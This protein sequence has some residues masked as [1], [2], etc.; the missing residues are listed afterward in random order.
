MQSHGKN[1]KKPFRNSSPA[2]EFRKKSLSGAW[3]GDFGTKER[4]KGQGKDKG[5]R[6]QT[7]EKIGSR[8]GD[9]TRTINGRRR[10]RA[11]KRYMRG[12]LKRCMAFCGRVETSEHRLGG[13][14]LKGYCMTR[15]LCIVS[16]ENDGIDY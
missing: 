9:A 16:A 1:S 6:V 7:G 10:K 3:D 4:D 13:M 12:T 15:E 8:G 5:R 14:W 2:L 11:S